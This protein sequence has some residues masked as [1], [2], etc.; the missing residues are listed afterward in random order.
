MPKLL[1]MPTHFSTPP[2]TAAELL[3]REFLT[4]R[5]KLLE[6][7]AGLDRLERANGD[8]TAD[9]RSRNLQRGIEDLLKTGADRAERLQLIFSQPYTGDWQSKFG[10]NAETNGKHE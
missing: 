6:L 5:A 2:L 3:D 1:I 4:L 9:P 8:V 10:I 7:A